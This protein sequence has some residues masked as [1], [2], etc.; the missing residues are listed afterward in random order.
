M[1]ADVTVASVY[2]AG[3]ASAP[4]RPST[5]VPAASA[6]RARARR[7]V[8][9]RAG[10]AAN[11]AAASRPQTRTRTCTHGCQD[12]VRLSSTPDHSAVAASMTDSRIRPAHWSRPRQP[13]TAPMPTKAPIAGASATV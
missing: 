3:P 11:T 1:C 4:V 5:T 6:V 2:A 9:T 10:Q 7:T 12:G 8:G 13:S